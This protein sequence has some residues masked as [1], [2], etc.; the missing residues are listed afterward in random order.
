[1]GSGVSLHRDMKYTQNSFRFTHT[2]AC[3][4]THTCVT[5]MSPTQASLDQS[6]SLLWKAAKISK[7]KWRILGGGTDTGSVGNSHHRN[8]DGQ[9]TLCVHAVTPST[10]HNNWDCKQ[11]NVQLVAM[12]TLLA[13]HHTDCKRH[14]REG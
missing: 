10:V 14:V 4:H 12:L 1:M 3:I 7:L 9:S 8:L 11:Y 13:N 5:N 2:H 6:F